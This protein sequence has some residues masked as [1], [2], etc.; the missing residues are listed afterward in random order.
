MEGLVRR[1]LADL[2]FRSTS[3]LSAEQYERLC[4]RLEKLDP[5]DLKTSAVASA[6]APED[7]VAKSEDF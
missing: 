1:E 6:T 3:D 2:G 7:S 4:G 5:E